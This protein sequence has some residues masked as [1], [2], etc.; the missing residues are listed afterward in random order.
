MYLL[1]KFQ[2]W[3]LT[4]KESPFRRQP[5]K[6]LKNVVAALLRKRSHRLFY[7]WSPNICICSKCRSPKAAFQN[8]F[9]HLTITLTVPCQWLKFQRNVIEFTNHLSSVKNS[10]MLWSNWRVIN[11]IPLIGIDIARGG[12]QHQCANLSSNQTSTT[13]QPSW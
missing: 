8:R 10:Q 9:Q 2:H 5:R 4:N 7:H 13:R 6:R 1:I 3:K 12:S 11:L